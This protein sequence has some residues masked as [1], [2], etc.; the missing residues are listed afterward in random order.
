MTVNLTAKFWHRSENV[1]CHC[2]LSG[3]ETIEWE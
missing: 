1:R 3:S 2:H